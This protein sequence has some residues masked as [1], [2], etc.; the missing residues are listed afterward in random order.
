[1]KEQEEKAEELRELDEMARQQALELKSVQIATD[2][3]HQ[4]NGQSNSDTSSTSV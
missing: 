4:S 1:M 3:N 2:D